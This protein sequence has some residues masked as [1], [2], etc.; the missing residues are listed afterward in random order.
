M[1]SN[2][3][4]I[5]SSLTLIMS[6]ETDR[7]N[8]RERGRDLAELAAV[9]IRLTGLLEGELAR[10]N[11]TQPGWADIMDEE[12]KAALSNG[13]IALGEASAA[14]A[15]VLERQIDL[16]VELMAAFEAEARRVS[17]SRAETYSANGILAPIDPATPI[18]INSEY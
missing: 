8:A 13:L 10:L 16:S 3:V 1:A 7:L 11:R 18:S 6:E 17:K 15:A 14:N 9:K 4:D 12:T 2:L 5:I